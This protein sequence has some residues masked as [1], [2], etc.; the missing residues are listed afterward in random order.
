[1]AFANT[2][3]FP[4]VGVPTLERPTFFKL[5]GTE[6]PGARLFKGQ[7]SPAMLGELPRTQAYS[8]PLSAAMAAARPELLCDPSKGEGGG[9]NTE[10]WRRQGQAQ[11]DWSPLSGLRRPCGE[12][13]WGEDG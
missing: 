2:G 10:A 3:I 5:P 12:Q 11:T 7:P 13:R 1:M 4:E 6:W 9:S 8:R